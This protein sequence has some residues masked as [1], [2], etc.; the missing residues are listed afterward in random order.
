MSSQTCVNASLA[1]EC[2]GA[3]TRTAHTQAQLLTKVLFVAGRGCA[4]AS[5]RCVRVCVCAN[6][7]FCAECSICVRVRRGSGHAVRHMSPSNHCRRALTVVCAQVARVAWHLG[8][9]LRKG[10][11]P[12]RRR[13]H[14]RSTSTRARILGPRPSSEHAARLPR[15]RSIGRR[16]IGVFDLFHS[17]RRQRIHACTTTHTHKLKPFTPP[18]AY[19]PPLHP[20]PCPKPPRATA[21]TMCT[22]APPAHRGFGPCQPQTRECTLEA[23]A[24]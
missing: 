11:C 18:F 10:L 22:R 9:W 13:G 19:P 6:A 1:I 12:A 3:C 5:R 8:R 4:K 17:S 16:R 24:S 23:R 15:R 2:Q 14:A 21:H 7:S 20:S